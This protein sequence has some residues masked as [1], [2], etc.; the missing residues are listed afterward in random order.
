MGCKRVLVGGWVVAAPVPFLLMWAPSWGWILFA[1][2]L[3]GI[4]QGLTWA[5]GAV[6]ALR[7]RETLAPSRIPP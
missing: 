7:M 2:L 5:S 1:N 3:L 6:V 4:S